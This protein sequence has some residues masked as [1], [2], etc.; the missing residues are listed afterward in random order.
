ML[1]KAAIF[2][3]FILLPHEVAIPFSP[4]LAAESSSQFPVIINAESAKKIIDAVRIDFQSVLPDSAKYANAEAQLEKIFA[5][6]PNVEGQRDTIRQFNALSR[7]LAVLAPDELARRVRSLG[8]SLTVRDAETEALIP[9]Y[10]RLQAKIRGQNFLASAAPPPKPAQLGKMPSF[11]DR[12]RVQTSFGDIADGSRARKGQEQILGADPPGQ[13]SPGNKAL[14]SQRAAVAATAAS[15]AGSHVDAMSRSLKTDEVPDVFVTNIFQLTP[16]FNTRVLR[17]KEA[18]LSA[19][20]AQGFL[21]PAARQSA[22]RLL[23]QT[24]EWL[25]AQEQ[26]QAA[27]RLLADLKAPE[28]REFMAQY[29]KL[30]AIVDESRRFAA[31]VAWQEKVDGFLSSTKLGYKYEERKLLLA[32]A[33]VETDRN[34][35]TRDIQKIQMSLRAFYQA[36]PEL[37]AYYQAHNASE[38]FHVDAVAKAGHT[39]LFNHTGSFVGVS[40]AIGKDNKINLESLTASGI[41]SDNEAR[42]MAPFLP[43]VSDRKRF[44]ILPSISIT[45]DGKKQLIYRL[46]IG[47]KPA[48]SVTY[49]DDRGAVVNHFKS[50]I[51]DFEQTKVYQGYFIKKD[52]AVDW[53]VEEEY[54]IKH[55]VSYDPT[56]S[57]QAAKGLSYTKTIW[58]GGQGRHVLID[59]KESQ[60]ANTWDALNHRVSW[61]MENVPVIQQVGIVAGFVANRGKDVGYGAS[62]VAAGIMNK[63]SSSPNRIAYQIPTHYQM[64]M[65]ASWEN[66]PLLMM[67]ELREKLGKDFEGYRRYWTGKYKESLLQETAD[68][69][70]AMELR[71][72]DFKIDDEELG[73]FLITGSAG[74]GFAGAGKDAAQRAA[75]SQ[76]FLGKSGNF[77]MASGIHAGDFV[78]QSLGFHAI[79]GFGVATSRAAKSANAPRWREGADFIVMGAQKTQSAYFNGIMAMQGGELGQALSHGNSDAAIAALAQI[80]AL[81]IM[82]GGDKKREQRTSPLEFNARVTTRE[83]FTTSPVGQLAV[84]AP[85]IAAA[86]AAA[87]SDVSKRLFDHLDPAQTR[88]RLQSVPAVEAATEVETI[89]PSEKRGAMDVERVRYEDGFAT[90]IDASLNGTKVTAEIIKGLGAGESRETEREAFDSHLKTARLFERILGS[91]GMAPKV[92]GEVDAG[93]NGAL[94][95]AW[96]RIKGKHIDTL[97]AREAVEYISPETLRQV[98]EGNRLLAEAGIGIS[99]VE[100]STIMPFVLTE[101]QE[102]NGVPRRAGDV[103]FVYFAD[104]TAILTDKRRL[105]QAPEFGSLVVAYRL[106]KA[107]ANVLA[108]PD[109]PLNELERGKEDFTPGAERSVKEA[110]NIHGKIRNYFNEPEGVLSPSVR[111]A[112]PG[113]PAAIEKGREADL[114]LA[115]E[116]ARQKYRKSQIGIID[117]ET[118]RAYAN[119]YPE[120]VDIGLGRVDGGLTGEDL[121]HAAREGTLA[122]GIPTVKWQGRNGDCTINALANNLAS[123]GKPVSVADIYKIISEHP[124]LGPEIANKISKSGLLPVEMYWVYKAVAEKIGV[125]IEVIP[126]RKIFETIAK[127]GRGAMV[128]IRA[129]HVEEH[130]VYVEGLVY[131]EGQPYVSIL[132]SGIGTRT[133]LPLDKFA[134]ILRTTGLMVK[135]ESRFPQN[136][137][138]N[139]IRFK[140]KIENRIRRGPDGWSKALSWITH[141]T[142]MEESG[143]RARS[144]KELVDRS[145]P[146]RYYHVHDAADPSLGVVA[147]LQR[148]G[149]LSISMVTKLPDEKRSASLR[150]KEQFKASVDFFKGRVKRIQGY[151]GE[152]LDHNLKTFNEL[153]GPSHAMPPEEAALLTWTGQQA[154]AAGFGRVVIPA[155]G[156]VGTPGLYEKARV[157]FEAGFLAST[158]P[159]SAGA[160][161][162]TIMELGKKYGFSSDEIAAL[163]PDIFEQEGY[164]YDKKSKRFFLSKEHYKKTLESGIAFDDKERPGTA[165]EPQAQRPTV[166]ATATT[167]DVVW[168]DTARREFAALP[169]EMAAGLQQ[170]LA[171]LQRDPRVSGSIKLKN[172]Q[173]RRIRKGNY[174]ILYSV[175]DKN[176]SIRI[177][178]VSTRADAYD[179]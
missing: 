144:A 32:Y 125:G 163:T 19:Q 156:L 116:L 37:K 69:M 36:H 166:K 178:H 40:L 53:A 71:R 62:V 42:Q 3:T 96:Q 6:N 152:L 33:A 46:S 18:A 111:N 129:S 131:K 29:A 138:A 51:S 41:L 147:T 30:S 114:V 45:P 154:K 59:S 123:S 49:L 98:A 134:T 165:V 113:Q 9:E 89:H 118:K 115:T 86:L 27:L 179:D 120:A 174:R 73:K 157:I 91:L 24:R 124:Q 85:V 61:I 121:D 101:A 104:F 142:P 25:R 94:A 97:T 110:L 67:Q 14:A 159:E 175:D 83:L 26:S 171:V 160:P 122:P 172:G 56:K 103:V 105:W 4:A 90:T 76:T 173:G 50:E 119:I 108:H 109:T 13:L 133:Y 143:P 100:E 87:A 43:D 38:Q 162:Y 77:A 63:A 16:A 1:K 117:T 31:L 151:W 93:G 55:I 99:R 28:N 12:G 95:W 17:L 107:K 15:G 84:A 72:S 146:G 169:K 11:P 168:K 79:A 140:E 126:E 158:N 47:G 70:T 34:A 164:Y 88:P 177:F 148:D 10:L 145:V 82:P 167:Y 52:G 80:A 106:E 137:T 68:P 130:A 64:P 150:G 139:L 132:D 21:P 66:A 153:T 149:T 20:A 112:N 136:L 75:Q 57:F 7:Q 44:I 170:K 48:T 65:M 58:D 161:V 102:I 176:H 2:F 78:I 155:D 5:R 92:I 35:E 81:G 54:K 22:G 135:P 127:E 74:E 39:A 141:S 128:G 8:N 23:F 60:D